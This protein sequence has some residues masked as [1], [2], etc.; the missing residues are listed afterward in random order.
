MLL[1]SQLTRKLVSKKLVA[2]GVIPM[3]HL[4]IGVKL[5]NK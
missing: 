2:C 4:D 3:S 1:Q 5:K